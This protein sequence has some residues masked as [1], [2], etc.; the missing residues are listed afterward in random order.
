MEYFSPQEYS[1]IKKQ[2]ISL[3][4]KKKNASEYQPDLMELKDAQN[5]VKWAERIL[6]KVIK[7]LKS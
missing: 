1:E 4:D 6:D 5:S 2:F 7:K 3:I